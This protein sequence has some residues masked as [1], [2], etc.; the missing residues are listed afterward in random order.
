MGGILEGIR[1][2]EEWTGQAA[3]EIGMRLE[4]LSEEQKTTWFTMA[5][6]KEEAAKSGT[7]GRTYE[8]G[9]QTWKNSVA[10]STHTKSHG[11]SN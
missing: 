9:E 11:N 5:K 8:D 4:E 3:E 10:N 2:Q 6:I 1:R 7:P